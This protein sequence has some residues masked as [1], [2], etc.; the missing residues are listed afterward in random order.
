MFLDLKQFSSLFFQ[1]AE[2]NN[3]SADELQ[4]AM[5]N[6]GSQQPITWLREN[7]S[8]MVDTVLTVATKYGRETKEN[9]VG[10]ISQKEAKESLKKHKGNIW[11]AVTEC[12]Q[13]RQKKVLKITIISSQSNKFVWLFHVGVTN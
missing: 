9:N 12:V 3:F 13:Q 5:T 11:Q 6:C 8:N 2:Q 4:I 1:E 10:T 7:W